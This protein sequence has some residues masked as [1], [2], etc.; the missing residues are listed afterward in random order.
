LKYLFYILVLI[1]LVFLGWKFG[2]DPH[3]FIAEDSASQPLEMPLADQP[4]PVEELDEAE[5][6]PT[7]ADPLMKP[8]EDLENPNGDLLCLEMGPLS[9]RS[10]PMAGGSFIPRLTAARQRWPIVRCS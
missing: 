1:N 10:P 8:P 2:V 3:R 6:L 9:E 4:L 5:L 7:E